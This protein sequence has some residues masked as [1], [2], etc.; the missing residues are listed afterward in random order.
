MS[1]AEGRF[2]H[3]LRDQ[4]ELILGML[5][6]NNGLASSRQLIVARYLERNEAVGDADSLID[7]PDGP[8]LDETLGAFTTSVSANDPP[9]RRA[10]VMRLDEWLALHGHKDAQLP[11]GAI[12]LHAALMKTA[13]VISRADRLARMGDL[14]SAYLQ[15]GKVRDTLGAVGFDVNCPDESC[16]DIA[17]IFLANLK[18][19]LFEYLIEGITRC[20]VGLSLP[21]RASVLRTVVPE[22][23]A[24][25]FRTVAE[26]LRGIPAEKEIASPFQS[27]DSIW[28]RYEDM[29]SDALLVE[30][31]NETIIAAKQNGVENIFFRNDPNSNKTYIEFGSDGKTSL[32]RRIHRS[33][34]RGIAARL[35]TIG[36][37]DSSEC[38]IP[39]T[40]LINFKEFGPLDIRLQITTN[41]SKDGYEDVVL[42]ILLPKQ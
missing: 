8:E 18:Q 6:S 14:N 29:P 39:Q 33:L 10:Y 24:P 17:D 22:I 3:C 20:L 13:K 34:M 21:Q 4:A 32:F 41:A 30:L 16:C 23:G 37:L 40:G 9:S 1:E 36:E 11:I 27:V 15:Y 38:R 42:R 19:Y 35:K 12:T 2:D 26:L 31:C 28:E 25:D 7:Q 5:C